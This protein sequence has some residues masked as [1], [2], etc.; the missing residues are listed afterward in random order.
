MTF[1]CKGECQASGDWSDEEKLKAYLTRY[2]C[3]FNRFSDLDPQK[4]DQ[5][6]MIFGRFVKTYQF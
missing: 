1:I 2:I 4:V 6:L 5:A 3:F